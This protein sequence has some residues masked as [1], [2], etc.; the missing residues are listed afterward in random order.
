MATAVDTG[1]GTRSG[2][3]RQKRWLTMS[4]REALFCYFFISPWVLGFLVFTAGPII[5]SLYFSFNDYTIIAPAE[6][7]GL[8]N[9]ERLFTNDDLFYKSLWN[10]FYYVAFG[11][12]LRI[13]FAFAL[14]TLL[15]Q[16]IR[17]RLFYRVAYYMPSIIPGVASAVLWII[18]LNPR[19]GLINLVLSLVGIDGPSWLGSP[20]WSKPA[21]IL[22]SLWGVGG[23][24]VLYLAGLQGIPES[25]Y[26]AADIDGASRW[27]KFWNVTIPLMT[28][29]ILYNLILQIIGSFQVFGSAFIMTHGGPLNSTLFYMLHLY[30]YAFQYFKMGYASALAWVLFV[31]ILFF[32]LITLKWSQAW[33]FYAGEK[34]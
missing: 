26:E 30:N 15:N 5:A 21:L 20:D 19:L 18:L 2:Q 13:V 27:S 1:T 22:M 14:A 11:V 28:P 17:G 6:W 8:K 34:Q 32:T 4:R 9:F 25:L 7:V 29:T 12:P 16:Q 3:G 31:I 33:V 23:S 24:M 10:T